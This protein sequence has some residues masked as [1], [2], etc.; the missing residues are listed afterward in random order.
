MANRVDRL[1]ACGNAVVPATVALA[2]V[3]LWEKLSQGCEY[4][5]NAWNLKRSGV[6]VAEDLSR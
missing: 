5:G 4:D 1:R 2:F 6:G 3:T